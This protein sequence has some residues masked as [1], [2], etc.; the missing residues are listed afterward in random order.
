MSVVHDF[1]SSLAK[2]HAAEEL[3]I[4]REI[5]RKAFPDMIAMV[6]YREDGEH[7]RAGIDRGIYLSNAKEILIDEK[8]RFNCAH[9]DIALEYISD[10]VSGTPGWVCKPLRCDYIAY[11]VV[12]TGKCYLLPVVQLQQAWR[13]RGDYWRM[14]YRERSAQNFGYKTWF[15]AVPANEVFTAMGQFLRVQFDG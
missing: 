2:S 9:N 1:R 14:Q 11:A 15:V 6:S 3:P 4:W 13:E 7:Q 5:Y 8:V 12:D 10:D